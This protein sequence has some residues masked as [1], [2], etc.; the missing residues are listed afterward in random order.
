[1]RTAGVPEGARRSEDNR[2][3]LEI[4]NPALASEGIWAHGT[5]RPEVG[6]LVISSIEAPELLKD[7]RLFQLV[8]FLTTHGP[9]G[10]VGIILNR[11]T[12][13]VLGRKPGGLPLELGGPVPIQRVF[14]DNMVYCGGFTAQQVIHIMHGHRLQNCVQ[15]VPGVYMAGEVAATEAVSGGRLPAGDFK[16]FSGA[17]TWAPGELEAQMDRGAWYTAACSRSLVLKSALQLPVPL[18]RE[19][20]QLMGGQY[21]EVASEGY[22]GDE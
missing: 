9:D 12:G 5:P 14:Q 19:V 20:L 16:F 8:I 18:W 4:Q 6:G 21:S 17:I 13:M 7:D 22:E 1:M 3:L 15:V 2:R 10:S 11:P